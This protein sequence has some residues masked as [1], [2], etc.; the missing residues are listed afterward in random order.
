MRGGAVAWDD[1]GASVMGRK[2]TVC[3]VAGAT[4]WRNHVMRDAGSERSPKVF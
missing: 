3:L 1:G 4:G 2:V